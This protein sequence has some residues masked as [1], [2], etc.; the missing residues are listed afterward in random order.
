MDYL[1]LQNS[2]AYILWFLPSLFWARIF[3]FLLLKYPRFTTLPWL[4]A[5]ILALIFD[6]KLPY[7][8]DL[9]LVGSV[10]GVAGYFIFKLP[11]G[12][13]CVAIF[14]ALSVFFYLFGVV[15]IE[16]RHFSWGGAMAFDVAFGAFLFCVFKTLPAGVLNTTKLAHIGRYAMFF[17]IF[18]AYTNNLAIVGLK[19]LGFTHYALVVALSLSMLLIMHGI[20]F[21]FFPN[22]AR[23]L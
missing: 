15:E 20:A 12:A 16:Y 1:H 7:V 11:R 19:A 3:V 9:G 8:L 14:G 22:L 13:L 18:H 10:F 5:V 17:Y 21:R 6:P 2:Y 4:C 23:R